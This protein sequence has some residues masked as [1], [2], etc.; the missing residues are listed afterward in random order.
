M[1]AWEA[2]GAEVLTAAVEVTDR[3]R[4]REL[5]AAAEQ[6]FGEIHGLI[7]AAEPA[8]PAAGEDGGLLRTAHGLLVLDE[9]LRES[10]PDFCFLVSAST[11]AAGFFMDALAH[12]GNGVAPGRWTSVTWE[13]PEDERGDADPTAAIERLFSLPPMA[14]VVVS[15]RSL[16]ADWS[17]LE[18]LREIEP[19]PRGEARGAPSRPRLRV[20]HVVPRDE[21]EAKIAEIWKELL[22]LAQVGVHDRFLEL[23][24]GSPGGGQMK[25]SLPASRMIT[26]MTEI[27]RVDLPIR[28]LFEASTV[29][30]LGRALKEIRQQQQQR[31]MQEMLKKIRE[32]S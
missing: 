24:G 20:E 29:A 27:F 28:L 31:E 14:R 22:G 11:S 21:T 12:Y 16:T 10:N 19:P 15:P 32:S 6:R 2:A 13:P 25:G 17:K 30:E 18:A 26:R 1:K 23:G 3:E 9:L 5:L 7:H 4:M 8:G